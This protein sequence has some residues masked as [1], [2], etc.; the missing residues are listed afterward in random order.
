MAQTEQNSFSPS[1]VDHHL[2]PRRHGEDEDG[3][4][5]V[6]LQD[7]ALQH[8]LHRRP[9][10]QGAAARQPPA[11]AHPQ[12]LQTVIGPVLM[13]GW[14]RHSAGRRGND[15]Y[16]HKLTR[17]SHRHSK[18]CFKYALAWSWVRPQERQE[19]GIADQ[20]HAL[21][22]AEC[23]Q[24]KFNFRGWPWPRTSKPIDP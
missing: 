13:G 4:G 1:H 18:T 11:S 24:W 17:I 8:L 10:R 9:P 14:R 2:W 15:F 20:F 22:C 5:D 23:R 3:E 16:N 21:T 6:L 12:G 19:N 7:G